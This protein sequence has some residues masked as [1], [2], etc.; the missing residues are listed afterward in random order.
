MPI[1]I[2]R[3]AQLEDFADYVHSVQ[4]ALKVIAR[5]PKGSASLPSEV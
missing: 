1:S 3:L 2:V 5:L 4:F